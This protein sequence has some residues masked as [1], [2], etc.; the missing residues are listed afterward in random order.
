MVTG[1]LHKEHGMWR[2]I[3]LKFYSILEEG[4]TKVR[5]LESHLSSNIS[6][7]GVEEC[8]QSIISLHFSHRIRFCDSREAS[9]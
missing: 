2:D 3:P 4:S 9:K 6:F 5:V 1:V 7:F 8:A